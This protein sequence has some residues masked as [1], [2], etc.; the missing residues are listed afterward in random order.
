MTHDLAAITRRYLAALEAGD[1]DAVFACFH[2]DMQQIEWPNRLT[3]RG[4]TRGVAHL[5]AS[6]AKGA[7]V[8]ANQRYDVSSLMVS[9]NEVAFE[10]VW[11]T[12]LKIP[13]GSLKAGD[14]MKAY[15]GAFLTFRDGLILSQ[16]NY[17]CF[18]P[19]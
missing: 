11:T 1:E 19:F 6:F 7:A 16:R 18:E 9:G 17:D 15:I 13:M 8:A 12:E 10:A 2:P 3:E 5:K 4:T 14:T